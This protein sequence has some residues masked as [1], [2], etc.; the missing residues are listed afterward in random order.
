MMKTRRSFLKSIMRGG[1]ALLA[2]TFFKPATARGDENK[3]VSVG[4]V[5]DYP[6]D[7][8]VV[9]PGESVVVVRQEKSIRAMS[10]LCTHR[11]CPVTPTQEDT[12][13]CYCHGSVFDLNGE[14]K[15]GPAEEPLPPVPVKI[16]GGEVFIQNIEH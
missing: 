7:K 2:T 13:T 8:A 12:L 5:Q 6:I 1:G 3:W 14:V 11:L 10:S 4:M 9:V 16:E 15:K